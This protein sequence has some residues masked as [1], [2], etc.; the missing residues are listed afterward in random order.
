MTRVS[1]GTDL[2]FRVRNSS[3]VGPNRFLLLQVHRTE[4]NFCYHT[5]KKTWQNTD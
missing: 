4:F 3:E 5:L 2:P 1:A